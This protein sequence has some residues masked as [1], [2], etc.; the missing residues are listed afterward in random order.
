MAT[1]AQS[2][3]R[4]GL[5]PSNMVINH[6]RDPA[7]GQFALIVK[8]EGE[9]DLDKLTEGFQYL[10]HTHPNLSAKIVL[11][12]DGYFYFDYYSVLFEEIG[13]T[14][15]ILSSDRWRLSIN[16]FLNDPLDREKALWE[17]K[18]LT[19]NTNHQLMIKFHHGCT[20]AKAAIYL[21]HDL[22]QHYQNE[23]TLSPFVAIPSFEAYSGKSSTKAQYIERWRSQKLI[24]GQRLETNAPR[25]ERQAESVFFSFKMGNLLQQCRSNHVTINSF[26]S[27]ALILAWQQVYHINQLSYVNVI[28]QRKHSEYIE[29]I[30][31]VSER[32]VGCFVTAAL[33]AHYD[34]ELFNSIWE[35][36]QAFQQQL[37]TLIP[38]MVHLPIESSVTDTDEIF[39]FTEEEEEEIKQPTVEETACFPLSIGSSNLG[40]A[41]IQS[42]YGELHIDNVNF[43][44]N[45]RAGIVEF[46]LNILTVEDTISC[47]ICYSDPCHSRTWILNE[48]R[49]FLAILNE[50]IEG[51][52]LDI[53]HTDNDL[54]QTELPDNVALFGSPLSNTLNST[55]HN[56]QVFK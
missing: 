8:F 48:G 18:L 50:L 41:P 37:Y 11:D 46:L 3:G 36:A 7:Q 30:T 16:D 14:H 55:D 40:T 26:L 35:F 23:T 2:R 25:E 12:E 31:P 43:T 6:D 20:D 1:T 54:Y 4:L 38:K 49:I 34:I 24:G 13:I 5:W 47:C 56:L 22:F 33:S 44:T 42:Q 53:T 21:I 51:F 52:A 15:D 45:H 19:E 9:I 39:G 28:N 27:A 10:Y 17:T 29:G 32:D